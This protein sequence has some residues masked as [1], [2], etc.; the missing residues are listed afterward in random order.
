MLAAGLVP[1]MLAG[2]VMMYRKRE[3]LRDHLTTLLAFGA[4]LFACV[5]LLGLYNHLRFGSWTE[6]GVSYTLQGW[7]SARTYKFYSLARAPAGMFYYVLSPPHLSA[8]FPFIRVDPALY[9]APPADFY[10]EPVAGILPSVPLLLILLL[11][12][13]LY[14]G[15]YHPPLWL[16]AAPLLVAGLVLLVQV[17][18]AA[19]TM[20]YEVDFVTLLLVPALLLWFAGVNA[21]K[22]A[23]VWRVL[24]VT[25]FACLLSTTIIVQTA[26]SLVG[27]Y[28][29]LKR[30]SPKTYET[31][32]SVFLPLERRLLRQ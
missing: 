5:L 30:G 19:G 26:Y 31:I 8:T 17:A 22:N 29:D 4:P 18:L 2:Y 20:R 16:V 11:A 14:F 1:A 3:P 21:L 15:W 27:Y 24:A 13:L 25:I 7:Q 6:F 10:L 23:R 9:L 12:P 32:H 28:D